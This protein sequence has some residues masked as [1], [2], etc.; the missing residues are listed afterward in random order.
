MTSTSIRGDERIEPVRRGIKRMMCY[1]H[2]EDAKRRAGRQ[3]RGRR[4][5]WSLQKEGRR[6]AWAS[7]I[8]QGRGR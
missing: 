4:L 8:V 1:I 2:H 5:A 6:L 3:A 7:P